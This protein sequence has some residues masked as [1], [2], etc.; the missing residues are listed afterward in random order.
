V[1]FALHWSSQET[2]AA[3]RRLKIACSTTRSHNTSAAMRGQNVD[4]DADFEL[5]IN[6]PVGGSQKD[7]LQCSPLRAPPRINPFVR[8]LVAAIEAGQRV[9][10]CDV[11]FPNGADN[12]LM[13]ELEKRGVL[14]KLA[15]YGGW[16]TAGNTTGT[17]LAQCAALRHSGDWQNIQSAV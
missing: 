8:E 12:L 1:R 15:V 2:R 5:F 11:A 7:E 3:S 9:A 6:A 17:V 10:L 4:E 13:S 14:G 16:N